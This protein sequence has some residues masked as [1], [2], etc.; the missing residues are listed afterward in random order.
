MQLNSVGDMQLNIA[1]DM[2]LSNVCDMQLSKYS[3]AMSVIRRMSVKPW[4]YLR[5]ACCTL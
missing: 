4:W 3:R 5:F 1:R 2:Q